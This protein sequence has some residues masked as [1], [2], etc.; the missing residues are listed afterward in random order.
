MVPQLF[1]VYVLFTM[2][3]L[4]PSLLAVLE[5]ERIVL[6]EHLDFAHLAVFLKEAAVLDVLHI[7]VVVQ[8]LLTIPLAV[9]SAVFT[10]GTLD[11]QAIEEKASL[12]VRLCAH[13]GP[14]FPRAVLQFVVAIAAN[15]VLTLAAGH[16]WLAQNA[17]TNDALDALDHFL[18]VE[19]N[20]N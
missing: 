9:T 16:D 2:H 10:V 18:V 19:V 4:N 5:V 20:L 11:F 7:I 13:F 15:R 6:S 8:Y 12:G 14:A 3:A 1:L 17:Q